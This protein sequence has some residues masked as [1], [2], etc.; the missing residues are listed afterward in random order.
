MSRSPLYVRNVGCWAGQRRP[1]LT[2]F[3]PSKLDLDTTELT[4]RPDV[5]LCFNPL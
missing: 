3:R 5:R 4:F 1:L 2:G